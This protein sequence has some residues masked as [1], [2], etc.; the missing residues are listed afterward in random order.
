MLEDDKRVVGLGDDSFVD[1]NRFAVLVLFPALTVHSF[2]ADGLVPMILDAG[3][4]CYW[5]PSLCLSMCYRCVRVMLSP[6]WLPLSSKPWQA[7]PVQI[8]LVWRSIH[9]R[10]DSGIPVAVIV[11]VES[12]AYLG[13]KGSLIQSIQAV[14]LLHLIQCSYNVFNYLFLSFLYQQN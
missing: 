4:D 8:V 14:C 11:D 2:V 6:L 3:L 13:L 12:L 9:D 7:I 5:Q 1:V 10:V